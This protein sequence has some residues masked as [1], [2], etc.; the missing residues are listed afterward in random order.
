MNDPLVSIVIPTHNGEKWIHETIGSILQQTYQNMEIIIIDDRSNDKTYE[1]VQSIIEKNINK[2]IIYIKNLQRNEECLSSRIG[3]DLSNGDYL[4]RLNHDDMLVDFGAIEHQV[5]VMRRTDADWSYYS[6]NVMGPDLQNTKVTYANLLPLP[7]RYS[8]RPIFQIFDNFILKFPYFALLKILI[9]NPIHCNT[10]MFKRESYMKSI[11]WSDVV[12]TDCDALL[13]YHLFLDRF[14]CVSIN[15]RI[16]AFLRIHPG[17][18]SNNPIYMRVRDQNRLD[19]IEKIVHEDY[20]IWLKLS[21]LSIKKLK[22]HK[23]MINNNF[24]FR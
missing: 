18:M 12:K 9:S 11:K 13:F 19:I 23:K 20:P 8:N 15:D 2:N 7:I 1:V 22:L 10:C 16:G 21:A 3:F 17:Q 5:N 14:K 6:Q 4:L 24:Y